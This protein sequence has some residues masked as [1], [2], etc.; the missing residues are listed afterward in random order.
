[1]GKA[2]F[3]GYYFKHQTQGRTWAFIPGIHGDGQGKE[4]AFLQVISDEGSHYLPFPKEA[5]ALHRKQA[6]IRLG[7]NRFG[8][9]GISV[10]LR[11]QGLDL[12]GSIAYDHPVA[13]H[14]NIMGPFRFFPFME[15]RHG[16]VSLRH[17]LSGSLAIDGKPLTFD[18]GLGYIEKDWGHSFPQSYLW[19]QCNAFESQKASIMLSIAKIPYLGLRFTGT[20]AS[21]LLGDKQYRLATYY[22][23]KVQRWD[24]LGACISQ[25]PYRL[26]VEREKAPDH[27]LSA[28]QGGA[29]G[30]SI[31]ECPSCT[32]EYRF[33]KKERPLFEG[34]TSMASFE[35][36]AE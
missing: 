34:R 18:G 22:G 8:L 1:M 32:A 21:I 19:T 23:A 15:C 13:L 24:A 30:R 33:Y 7:N 29:M 6:A 11:E 35:Y 4:E 10:D 25:G 36:V 9:E 20:I 16:V 26:E 3:E 2:Y 17:G 27:M 14:G 31:R 5:F 12:A 28:P